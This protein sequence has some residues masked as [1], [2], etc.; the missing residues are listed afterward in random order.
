MLTEYRLLDP[1]SKLTEDRLSDPVP[2]G[3]PAASPIRF[4]A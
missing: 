3:R 1:R 2:R 4:L